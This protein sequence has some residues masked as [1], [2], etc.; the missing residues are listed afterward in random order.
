MKTLP[1]LLL[2]DDDIEIHH[3]VE[4]AVPSLVHFHAEL[5]P[6]NAMTRL[7]EG[8]I[9]VLIVDLNLSADENGYQF[10]ERAKRILPALPPLVLIL[11]ASENEADEVKAYALGATAFVQK[12][13]RPQAFRALLEK[14]LKL[15]LGEESE[16]VEVGPFRLDKS[17]LKIW[18]KQN[19]ES[20]E[21]ILTIK[22]FQLLLKLIQRPDQV[23]SREQLLEDVWG[24][25]GDIQSRTVDTHVSSLR[26]KLGPSGEGLHSV[27][28]AGYK[29]SPF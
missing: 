1:S 17:R 12:P 3:I 8:G 27:R 9:D 16:I 11:T 15:V 5:L 29:W 22:E 14:H 26:K 20:H 2:L 13:I 25:D 10:L 6:Q 19:N 7:Q 18:V 21:V 4:K 23:F 28:G 24:H